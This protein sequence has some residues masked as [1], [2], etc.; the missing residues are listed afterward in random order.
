MKSSIKFIGNTKCNLCACILFL[1]GSHLPQYLKTFFRMH[2]HTM[3]V[4]VVLR[5]PKSHHIK[6][7]RGIDA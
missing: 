5:K 2:F 4:Y 1:K 7:F 3:C 6:H